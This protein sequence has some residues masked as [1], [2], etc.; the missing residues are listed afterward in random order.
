MFCRQ[1]T[2]QGPMQSGASSRYRLKA[3]LVKGL[4]A[5]LPSGPLP[6]DAAARVD[7]ADAHRA[8]GPRLG[9][10]PAIAGLHVGAGG[11]FELFV[12]L[13]LELDDFVSADAGVLRRARQ[14]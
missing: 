4:A 7:R 5:S 6:P 14:A 10:I 1:Y 13:R 12:I 8:P 9:R 11:E 2:S 3:A